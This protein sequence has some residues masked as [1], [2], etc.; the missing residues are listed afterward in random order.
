MTYYQNGAS[1]KDAVTAAY[2][3]LY[4]SITEAVAAGAADIKDTLFG[5]G[6]VAD[7]SQGVYFSVFVGADGTEDQEVYK[8]CFIT[9]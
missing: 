6:Y 7:Y 3:G 1:S 8:L 2:V 9:Q 4:S 5:T